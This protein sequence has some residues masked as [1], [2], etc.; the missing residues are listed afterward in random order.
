[1]ASLHR[2][3]L[4]PHLRSIA[5]VV[6]LLSIVIPGQ[7]FGQTPPSPPSS[8]SPSTSG[9]ATVQIGPVLVSDDFQTPERGLLP[10][11]S[12]DP[13]SYEQGYESGYYVV[14]AVDEE[15]DGVVELPLPGSYRDTRLSVDVRSIGD[16]AGFVYLEC[17]RSG[18]NGYVG[19]FL[20][21]EGWYGIG[22]MQNG[23]ISAISPVSFSP[24][25]R[26]RQNGV[27]LALTCVG[28]E[29]SLSLA[30]IQLASARDLA[31]T[32]GGLRL[33][34]EAFSSDEEPGSLEF[35]LA[36]LVANQATAE[37]QSPPTPTVTPTA[38]ATPATP[39]GTPATPAATP[40]TRTPTL[41]PLSEADVAAMVAPSVVRI[42]SPR[43]SGSGVKVGEGVI[44]NEHVI[45]GQQQVQIERNDGT[46]GSATVVR[47][48]PGFDLALLS[49]DGELPALEIESTAQQRQ[50]DQVLVMGYPGGLPGQ[51]SLSRGLLSAVRE[52]DGVTYV[53]TD[54]SVT[55][56]SSGGAIVNM[57]GRLIGVTRGAFGTS[58]SLNFGI[59]GE[60][61]RAFLS[62]AN[63]L[64]PDP[65]E[66]DDSMQ[67]ARPLIVGA[68]PALHS[69]HVPGDQD[70]ISLAVMEGTQVAVFTDSPRCDTVLRLYAPD[71]MTVL[72]VDDDGGRGASSWI[73]FTAE[74]TATYFAQVTHFDRG[75]FCPS[76]YLAARA[77]SEGSTDVVSASPPHQSSLSGSVPRRLSPEWS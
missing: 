7:A 28:D 77:L 63:L 71:G 37:A 39:A 49:I 18:N 10:P 45:R 68:P 61:V 54:A 46:R 26:L 11:A 75:G 41:V 19:A 48:D 3:V 43:G 52:I 57:R 42:S 59:A 20:M 21:D 29:I 73:D 16:R 36:N 12:V 22:R 15:W 4:R 64:G 2:R 74:E 38:T 5:A 47:S 50:G 35:R 32:E 60:S 34:L 69:L 13:E 14:R 65:F 30:G 23:R 27:N 70:W 76:Y 53:Q 6:L 62:G 44:T 72:D 24:Y 58:G 25:G 40:A 55:F 9:A 56:G 31:F 66:P 1:M 51:A 8:P 67:Q 17:R 33:T